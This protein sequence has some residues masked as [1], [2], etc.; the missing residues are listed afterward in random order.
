MSTPRNAV[1]RYAPLT[2]SAG[3]FAV[4]LMTQAFAAFVLYF[5]VDYLGASPLYISYAMAVHGI[6]N[7]VLNPLV[8]Q[9]SDATRTRFGRRIPYI[10]FGFLPLALVYGLLW[11][12]PA[13]PNLLVLYF[14]FIV[15][16]YDSL[17]VLV[18]LNWTA[19]YPEMF[20]TPEERTSVA[21]LRQFFGFLGM[22]SGMV[23][24]PLIASRTGWSAFGWIA[25]GFVSL[26]LGVSLLGAREREPSTTGTLPL[27][28]SL[29][30][31]LTNRTFLVFVVANLAVQTGFALLTATVP[32]YAK[33]LLRLP[34][35]KTALLY[36]AILLPSLLAMFIWG[37]V[38]KYVP[39]RR[40]VITALVY[41]SALLV[42][43]FFVTNL[44]IAL[45]A[46]VLF[47][48]GLAGVVILFDILLAEVIDDDARRNGVRRE[49]I[50]YGVNGFVIR[51]SV[52]LQAILTGTVLTLG[53]YVPHAA[54]QVPSALLA[55]RSLMGIWPMFFLLVAILLF[56]V[57]PLGRFPQ[58]P[59]APPS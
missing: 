46:G 16:L 12:P 11:N 30:V 27:W 49:G 36:A 55:I 57:F 54:S 26:F 53:G 25:A 8:G 33:Y 4:G 28:T 29:K 7:A 56:R 6:F 38:L 23:I 21:A 47:G 39:P 51:L 50:Y 45:A 44:A 48:F 17:F 59:D 52:T 9:L 1:P 2:Y 20:P 58:N 5:Y 34:E 18:V 24:P 14:L 3:N 35:E 22:I 15:F 40:A 19:L 42:S 43:F 31:T 13:N 10:A 37:Y 32:F 41:L